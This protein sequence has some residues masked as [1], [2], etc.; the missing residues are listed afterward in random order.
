MPQKMRMTLTCLVLAVALVAASVSSLTLQTVA[1][2]HRHG[3]RTPMPSV[4]ASALCPGGAAGCG[5]LTLQG[6]QMLTNLGR[7]LRHHYNQTIEPYSFYNPDVVHTQST[8]VDRT[9]QSADALLRGLYE[10]LEGTPE[11]VYPVVN[12]RDISRET[13]LLVWDGWPALVM[14]SAATDSQFFPMLS[15]DL[16]QN[17]VNASVLAAV[18]EE[19]GLN[20]E[21]NPTLPT[22]FP[23][24]CAIDAQ[25][26][27]S[28]AITTGTT[29][30]FPVTGQFYPNL[31]EALVT[32]NEY[33]MGKFDEETNDGKFLAA[34][35]SFGYP[36]ALALLS[37]LADGGRS[38]T[39]YS[40]H[41]ITLIPLYN[42]L[43][44]FTM[45]N[46]RF[47]AAMIFE[48]WQ[49]DDSSPVFIVAKSGEPGQTPESNFTYTFQNF[50]L[51][52]MTA[53]G[54]VYHSLS[55]CPIGDL[56][57]YVS[58]RAP[59][60]P[61]GICYTSDS[62]QLA[63]NCTAGDSAPPETYCS[64]YRGMCLDACGDDGAMTADLLCVPIPSST[65]RAPPKKPGGPKQPTRQHYGSTQHGAKRSVDRH[66]RG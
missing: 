9:I 27:Y 64:Y 3:A 33:A 41:D 24:Q 51:T 12:T 53:S 16:L 34:V 8:D 49:P 55:G 36:L 59:Q 14:W 22:F 45:L 13:E 61:R 48:S 35:G 63:L 60:S 47:G 17:V 6:K 42:A 58:S 30:K 31:V 50:S 54:A 25:D 46:P 5:I 1:V 37:H 38:L 23:F 43:G 15:N 21:C 4:N 28:A 29:G 57:R 32:Y 20:E 65:V 26:M 2:I 56:R 62:T 7:Y 40:G 18:G 19:I 11:M 44:N 39:H 66:R 52:C 10:H